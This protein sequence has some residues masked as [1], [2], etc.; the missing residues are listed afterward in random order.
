MGHRRRGKDRKKKQIHRRN[1]A[2]WRRIPRVTYAPY[3]SLPAGRAAGCVNF[4]LCRPDPIDGAPR[5][6]IFRAMAAAG[7]SEL[8][9][10]YMRVGEDWIAAI[11]EEEALALPDHSMRAMERWD[12]TH[13][14]VDDIEAEARMAAWLIMRRCG[15]SIT[16]FSAV[17]RRTFSPR[18]RQCH[19]LSSPPEREVADGPSKAG[20][21]APH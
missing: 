3:L 11:R 20:R 19:L 18:P 16:E 8:R 13:M 10:T 14:K 2:L 17:R 7:P 6:S 1:I 4:R 15:K 12:E 21:T 5:A 9:L